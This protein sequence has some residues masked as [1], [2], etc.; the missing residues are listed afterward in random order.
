MLELVLYQ[1]SAENNRVDKSPFL[2]LVRTIEGT[3]R[4]SSSI[5]TPSI[6]LELPNQADSLLIDADDEIVSGGDSDVVVDS[7]LIYSF[8]YVYIKMFSRFYYVDNITCLRSHVFLVNLVVDPL[9]STKDALVD[10]DGYVERNEHDFS[11][12]LEDPLIPF[13]FDKAIEEDDNLDAGSLVNTIFRTDIDPQTPNIVATFV[14]VWPSTQPGKIDPPEDTDLNV[15]TEK[16]FANPDSAFVLTPADVEQI[17]K[18]FIIEGGE[19]ISYVKGMVALPY[20][21]NHAVEKSDVKAGEDFEIPFI[22]RGPI[23]FY[24]L[25]AYKIR[26]M[27]DYITIA[28]FTMPEVVDFV[29]LPPYS[30]YELY[31]P[32]CG[33]TTLNINDVGG[34]RLIV[35]Y[36]VE[37]S[38]GSATAFVWNK[39]KKRLVYSSNCQLGA[40][41]SI[42]T[43]NQQEIQARKQANGLN[44]AIGLISSVLTT[45]F[46]VA[47]E[48]PIAIA[49]GIMGG[50]KAMTNHINSNA[51]LFERASF[52]AS[53]SRACLYSPLKVRLR[54]TRSV[55]SRDLD[56]AG[57]ARQFGRP[58]R[59]VRRLGT[60]TG[61]TTI[62]KIHLEN[63]IATKR[64][65]EEIER[66]FSQ[67]VI[68]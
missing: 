41:L 59:E 15:I 14:Y 62:S 21:P 24:G 31:I 45:A 9:M 65:K 51:M 54:I 27:S 42:A 55:V 43:T 35:Y 49:G 1:N 39:T 29:D 61:F 57:F 6:V 13:E 2:A 23:D 22:G 37:Y 66:L 12:I 10:L 53:G 32:F 20:V 34:C 18:Y 63:I 3:L 44:L 25:K 30:N 19:K 36:A 40:Q 67:G 38:D 64:E 5:I 8:N 7:S 4:E 50:A 16:N 26:V 68:L 46:G 28:D 48:N 58:L 17:N 52:T 56:L 47:T 11:T 60:L 33:W